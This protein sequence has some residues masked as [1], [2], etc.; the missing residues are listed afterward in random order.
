MVNAT[1]AELKALGVPFFGMRPELITKDN[2]D[3]TTLQENNLQEGSGAHTRSTIR[4]SEL[5]QL[6]K[7]MLELLEDLCKE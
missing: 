5:M 1:T 4:Q 2:E 6:Q 7:R 3:G